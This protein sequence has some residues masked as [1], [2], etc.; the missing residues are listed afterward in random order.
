MTPAEIFALGMQ[1]LQLVQK[2]YA[3]GHRNAT[4]TEENEL[5]AAFT[6]ARARLADSIARREAGERP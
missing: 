3:E 1:A 5:E 2:L 6:K 4:P